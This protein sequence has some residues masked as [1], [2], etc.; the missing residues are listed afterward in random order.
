MDALHRL[1]S[2]GAAP[3]E[4]APHVLGLA[5]AALPVGWSAVRSFRFQ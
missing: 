5:I 4:A 2:F 3:A 1:I